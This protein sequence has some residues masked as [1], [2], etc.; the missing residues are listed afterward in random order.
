[1]RLRQVKV[2]LLVAIAAV[3][4]YRTL[5]GGQIVATRAPSTKNKNS[6]VYFLDSTNTTFV[7][8]IPKIKFF[9]VGWSTNTDDW[10]THHPEW[11]VAEENDLFTCFRETN[12]TVW[13]RVYDNQFRN[14][15][16]KVYTRHMWSSGFGTDLEN[17][18]LGL[19]KA[20]ELKKPLAMTLIPPKRWWHYSANKADG[21]NAT[22]PER[23][24]SCY[25]LPL[26]NCKPNDRQIDKDGVRMV[27]KY[28]KDFLPVYSYVT[29]QQQWLRKQV[30]DLSK[31]IV[32]KLA[33]SC[34]V[35]HV[36]R[37][38]VVLHGSQARKYFPIS[39][40]VELLPT[41]SD[42]VLLLTD[43]ANA[44]DEALEFHPNI[45]WVYL[46]R[47][48]HRGTSGGWEEQV[49]SKDPKSEVVTILSILR[50]V[51]RCST[52]IH[53]RSKFADALSR[54]MGPN[55]TKLQVDSN[56][57]D[58]L[59]ANNSGSV[60]QLTEL[61]DAKRRNKDGYFEVATTNGEN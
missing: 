38:D 24:M 20:M 48:R 46:D 12:N 5:Q 3:L 22:C 13:Q 26:T 55:V 14:D 16:S 43:D 18:V 37:A 8:P 32:D 49:P 10:W 11:E 36:R 51:P 53:S 31:P 42:P 21:S 2:L 57:S 1:M 54:V 23:D 58:V 27:R 50:L 19:Q 44:I 35:I 29:R 30:Y 59:H 34:S 33:S 7:P 17:V 6:A 39:A 25:F 52:L 61:L 4:F 15:C 45:N 60:T 47:P 56:I 40:Y 41:R 9:C 28:V